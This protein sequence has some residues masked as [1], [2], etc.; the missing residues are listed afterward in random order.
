MLLKLLNLPFTC[1]VEHIVKN[2]KMLGTG[3]SSFSHNVSKG[4][5]SKRVKK[6]KTPLSSERISL[7][8]N[9]KLQTYQIEKFCRRHNKS[10]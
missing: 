4:F 10:A 9:T 5:F 1:M 7:Y 8:K 3:I 2:E 6:K